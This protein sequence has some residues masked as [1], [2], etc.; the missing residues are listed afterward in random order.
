MY[1]S[2]HVRRRANAPRRGKERVCLEFYDSLPLWGQKE[3]YFLK[4]PCITLRDET[5]WEETLENRC[6]LLVGADEDQI[7]AAA[8]RSQSAG[9]WGNHYGN[10]N[11]AQVIVE[12][13]QARVS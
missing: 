2:L 4:V 9:P 11:A 10:G 12:N 7:V 8:S 1:A 13:L 5:E 3:A 6:N